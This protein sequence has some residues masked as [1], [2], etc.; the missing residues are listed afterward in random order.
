MPKPAK[1]KAAKP[2]PAKAQAGQPL[3]LWE[4]YQILTSPPL[5]GQ[6]EAAYIHCDGGFMGFS[7]FVYRVTSSQGEV[8][9]RKQE[10]EFTDRPKNSKNWRVWIV[11]FKPG[12]NKKT[13]SASGDHTC[14]DLRTAAR[15][16]LGQ[17]GISH[18]AFA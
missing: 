17:V 15:I 12:T 4:A 13:G 1:I 6:L 5:C 14:G 10:S 2:T 3:P 11:T 7:D 8:R 9:H 16:A 18:P